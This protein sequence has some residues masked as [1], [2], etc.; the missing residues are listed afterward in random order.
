MSIVDNCGRSPTI[1]CIHANG[2]DVEALAEK[3]AGAGFKMDKGYGDFKKALG[4]V[5]A[6]GLSPIRE[7]TLQLLDDPAELDKLLDNGA[8]KA[9]EVARPNLLRTWERMGLG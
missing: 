6:E 3:A 1:S 7:R 9:R 5:V 2:A 4:E 8:E